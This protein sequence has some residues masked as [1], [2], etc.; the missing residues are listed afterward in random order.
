[1][2]ALWT[3]AALAGGFETR[4]EHRVIDAPP[5][6]VW[7]VMTEFDGYPDWNPWITWAEGTVEMGAKV[8]IE[9]QLNGRTKGVSHRVTEV[10]APTRFCWLDRGWFTPVARGGR[11][12]TLTPEGAGTSYTVELFVDGPMAGTVERRFGA[13]LTAGLAAE[14]DALVTEAEARALDARWQE[15]EATVRASAKLRWKDQAPAEWG[16]TKHALL[17]LAVGLGPPEP[18][19]ALW[20]DPSA[21]VGWSVHD[22]ERRQTAFLLYVEMGRAAEDA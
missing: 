6:V 21:S 13:T 22:A 10:E 20:P 14:T 3:A 9:V 12:R 5:E 17:D 8:P 19:P 11:C 1:V 18:V 15:V 7:A 16:L 4:S 2:L